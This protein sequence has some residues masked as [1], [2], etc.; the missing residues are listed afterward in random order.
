MRDGALFRGGVVAGSV[1]GAIRRDL[2]G[3]CQ[4]DAAHGK[5]GGGT[6]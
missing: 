2:P 3:S 6:R 4:V 5:L 1:R